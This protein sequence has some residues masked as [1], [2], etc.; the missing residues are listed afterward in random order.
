MN[1]ALIN[2]VVTATFFTSHTSEQ[3]LLLCR[4]VITRAEGNGSGLRFGA[5]HF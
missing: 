3:D 1:D 4:Y 2:L 5:A